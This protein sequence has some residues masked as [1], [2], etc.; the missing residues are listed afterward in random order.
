MVN[1][2][3]KLARKARET[4]KVVTR[5]RSKVGTP[6]LHPGARVLT[7]R[8]GCC[9]NLTGGSPVK[10]SAESEASIRRQSLR[11]QAIQRAS[12]S[13]GKLPHSPQARC[14]CLIR[15]ARGL[16]APPFQ[17]P[18]APILHTSSNLS[19]TGHASPTTLPDRTAFLL[20]PT[21]LKPKLGL[22]MRTRRIWQGPGV[23]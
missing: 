11:G 4:F 2:G 12:A 16:C 6:A 22:L 14:A 15:G 10:Q 13:P 17:I 23:W 3:S 8:G 21:P 1:K 18:R 7:A 19:G 9:E 20:P 5:G